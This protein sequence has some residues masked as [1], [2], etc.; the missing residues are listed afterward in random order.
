MNNYVITIARGY[1]SGGREVGFK[2]S[3]KLGIPCYW[4]QI[5]KMASEYSGLNES[6]F[7]KVDEKLKGGYLL[8]RLKSQPNADEIVEPN[9]KSFV[10]DVNLF[11]I[12][13]RIIRELA[14][15]ESCIIIGKCSNYLLKDY[16][17][18]V[19]VYIE[20]PR[21][22]CLARIQ[23]YLGVDE[24]EAAEQIYRTDKYRADYYKYYTGGQVWTNPTAYDMT[25]NSDR[26][27]IENCA[28]L[29][30]EYL[31]M[32]GKLKK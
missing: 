16:D 29:V 6:L 18:V 32:S 11:N 27:G 25:L 17:N 9:D 28:N 3:E 14:M 19:S 15:T 7:N 1:G 10:S 8:N 12:Q 24:V 13:K 22:A 20:A 30:I 5:T 31:K 23:Q 2:L 21:K 26:L 4:T